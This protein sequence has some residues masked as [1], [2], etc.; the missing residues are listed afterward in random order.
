MKKFGMLKSA[1]CA[2]SLSVTQLS[3]A[4]LPPFPEIYQCGFRS[5]FGFACVNTKTEERERRALA[6]PEMDGAQ[7]MS[8]EDYRKSEQ[9]IESVKEIAQR[10]CN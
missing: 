2:I 4:S 5:T 10:R 3:C 6:D 9:W 1:L 8:L 7:C